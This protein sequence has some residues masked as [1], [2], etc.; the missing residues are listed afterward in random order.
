MTV[1]TQ[2]IQIKDANGT[3]QPFYV[4]ND[5]TANSFASSPG[6][7]TQ[8]PLDNGEIV[9]GGDAVDAINAGHRTAGGTLQTT[10]AAGFYVNEISTAGTVAA[11]GTIFV[12]QNT[13]WNVT[14]GSG[15]VS[16]NASDDGVVISGFG[17]Q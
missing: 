6:Q 17:L 8:L 12:P 11:D 2:V 15:P 14:P 3:N 13:I 7:R 5:G 10:N 4:V 1:T 16:I 9:T